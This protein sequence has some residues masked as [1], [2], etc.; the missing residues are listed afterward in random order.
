MTLSRARYV[1]LANFTFALSVLMAVHSKE[2]EAVVDPG[3]A[4]IADLRVKM[5]W[6]SSKSG[7]G[8]GFSRR[9]VMLS[10]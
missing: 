2:V 3:G 6:I 7:L 1:K 4:R 8:I 5:I 10:C 9:S